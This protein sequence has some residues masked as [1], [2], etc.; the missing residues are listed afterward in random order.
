MYSN[1]KHIESSYNV[2]DIGS[3]MYDI[4]RKNKPKKIVEF[5]VLYGYSTVAMAQAIR[6]NGEG[7]INAYDLF[8]E[9]EYKNGVKEI[10]EHNLD[11]YN[12]K[13]KVTLDQ[14]DFYEWLENPEPFD[15]LHFDIS[16]DSDIIKLVKEKLTKQIED[17]A[18][19]LFE[20]GGVIR[21]DVEWMVKYGNTKMNPLKDELKFTVLSEEHPTISKYD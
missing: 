6:D 1:P 11:F 19:V 2:H 9:Y 20:G 3:I 13:N 15:L 4:V 14:C 16:N 8:D 10:V 18:I 12:L 21:D 7:H 17:G 5:G